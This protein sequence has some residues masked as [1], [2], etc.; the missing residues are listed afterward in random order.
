MQDII[1]EVQQQATADGAFGRG[2]SRYL[3]PTRSDVE[4]PPGAAWCTVKVKSALLNLTLNCCLHTSSG[5]L[6][7][8][9]PPHVTSLLH[10]LQIYSPW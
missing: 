4:L 5:Q 8:V 10:N 2:T 6:P 7:P 1:D 3:D 9:P